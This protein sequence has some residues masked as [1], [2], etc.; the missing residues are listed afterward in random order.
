MNEAARHDKKVV[1]FVGHSG[2]GKTTLATRVTH[3]LATKGIRVSVLKNAHHDFD[4]DRPGKDS[5]RYR[6]SGAREVMVRSG[7]RYAML[8]ECPEQPSVEELLALFTRAELVIVEGFKNE[9]EFPKIE[10]R[11]RG[12]SDHAAPLWPDNPQI[13]ALATDDPEA[14]RA[15][16]EAGLTVLSVNDPEAVAEYIESQL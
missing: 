8:V 9:G 16:R 12:A 1:G 15:A 3:L 13:R 4:M 10:V 5:W 14:A 2:A 7:G 11:R 6:E